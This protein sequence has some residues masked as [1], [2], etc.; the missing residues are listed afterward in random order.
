MI[1]IKKEDVGNWMLVEYL[2]TLHSVREKLRF[3]EQK[4]Q[5]SWETFN[6]HITSS[7]QEDFSQWDDYIE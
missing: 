5:Q 1:T 3:F 7:M 6:T 4:Y 2:S